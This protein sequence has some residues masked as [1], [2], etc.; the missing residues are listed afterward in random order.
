MDN[1]KR[2]FEELRNILQKLDRS[3]DEAQQ[4]RTHGSTPPVPAPVHHQSQSAT[5]PHS[6]IIPAA[7]ASPAIIPDTNGNAEE[8]PGRLKAK[9]LRRPRPEGSGPSHGWVH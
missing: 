9:P 5:S 7:P 3:L 6:P 1:G 8:P 2:E 4:K